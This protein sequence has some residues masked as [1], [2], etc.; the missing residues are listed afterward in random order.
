MFFDRSDQLY[1]QLSSPVAGLR[2]SCEP[3]ADKLEKVVSIWIEY[4][5][6]EVDMPASATPIKILSSPLEV[7]H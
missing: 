2:V 4:G 1:F 3:E 6:D 5:Y 7:L